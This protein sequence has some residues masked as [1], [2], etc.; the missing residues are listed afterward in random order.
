[1]G[2]ADN[3]APFRLPD[4][5]VVKKYEATLVKEIG[6]SFDHKDVKAGHLLV[7]VTSS[8]VSAWNLRCSRLFAKAY[9]ALG[10]AKTTDIKKVMSLFQGQ[11]K[12]MK[13]AHSKLTRDMLPPEGR[14]KLAKDATRQR[15][16][17]R[18]REVSFKSNVL[19][20]YLPLLTSTQVGLT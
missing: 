14:A 8:H 1:M 10:N 19:P 6:P 2:R 13:K 17:S 4:A 12:G 20:L 15:E 5:A 9:V 3:E 11:I 7:D 18:V 16:Y